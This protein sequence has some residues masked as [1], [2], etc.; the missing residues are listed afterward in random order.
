MNALIQC[1]VMMNQTGV[2]TNK[3]PHAAFASQPAR[4]RH[5][6]NCETVFLGSECVCSVGVLTWSSVSKRWCCGFFSI[7]ILYCVSSYIKLVWKEC[8]QVRYEQDQTSSSASK[9]FESVRLD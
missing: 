1:T 8:G 3:R 2:S 5:C 4:E 9:P 6:D 7:L